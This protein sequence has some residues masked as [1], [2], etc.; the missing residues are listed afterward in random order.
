MERIDMRKG[1]YLSDENVRRIKMQHIE[2]LKHFE[3]FYYDEETGERMKTLLREYHSKSK[4]R[5]TVEV[6]IEELDQDQQ[7]ELVSRF[8]EASL[9]EAVGDILREGGNCF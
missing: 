5:S 4:A 2:N 6:G 1:M 7:G 8:V 9:A 3:G